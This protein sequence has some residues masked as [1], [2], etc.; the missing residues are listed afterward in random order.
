[1]MSYISID[2]MSSKYLQLFL[3]CI[4]TLM[5]AAP[6]TCHSAH[7]ETLDHPQRLPYKLQVEP[8]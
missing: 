8:G 4:S 7:G 2:K 5:V 3:T 1:M 6:M